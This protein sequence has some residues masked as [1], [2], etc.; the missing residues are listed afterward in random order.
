VIKNPTHLE[1]VTAVPCEITECDNTQ[2]VE[3]CWNMHQRLAKISTHRR[4]KA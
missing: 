4:K 2:V 3:L 1:C